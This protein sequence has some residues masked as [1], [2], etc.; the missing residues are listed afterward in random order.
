M[1]TTP[2]PLD[3][4]TAVSALLSTSYHYCTRTR[5]EQFWVECKVFDV[6]SKNFSGRLAKKDLNIFSDPQLDGF[7]KPHVLA[8]QSTAGKVS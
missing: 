2:K 4:C 7:N 5:V 8:N 1:P 3:H 6:L